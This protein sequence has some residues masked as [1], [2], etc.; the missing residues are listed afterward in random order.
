MHLVGPGTRTLHLRHRQLQGEH[1][2][3]RL[4]GE[5]HDSIRLG[6]RPKVSRKGA[7]HTHKVLA[8][9]ASRTQGQRIVLK[10]FLQLNT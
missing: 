7:T 4:C 2:A 6:Y 9:F 8:Q 3:R 10:T 5:C 1:G